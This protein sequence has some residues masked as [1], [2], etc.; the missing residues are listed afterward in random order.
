MKEIK[1]YKKRLNTKLKSI[2]EKM[3]KQIT[4]IYKTILTKILQIKINTIL[5][6][7]YLSK[8]IQ[9]SITNIKSY[10]A[11]IVITKT[12]QYVCDNLIFK[13][14]WKLKLRIISLWLKQR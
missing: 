4:K 11:N 6:N 1:N 14:D 10:I 2:Q 8:L 9:K 3:L 7:I 12:T 13:R 5:I